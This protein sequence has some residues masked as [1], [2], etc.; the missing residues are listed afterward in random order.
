MGLRGVPMRF[1]GFGMVRGG[2]VVIVFR[3]WL[4]L[5]LLKH[6][7]GHHHGISAR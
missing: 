2:F 1:G 6:S 3:H 4:L 7:D 5:M